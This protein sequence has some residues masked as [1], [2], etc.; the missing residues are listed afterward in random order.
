MHLLRNTII[1]FCFSDTYRALAISF[2][3]YLQLCPA[4]QFHPEFLEVNIGG[5]EMIDSLLAAPNV[6]TFC[7]SLYLS[8]VRVLIM[9]LYKMIRFY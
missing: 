4:V 6:L 5:T 1:G 7:G 9:D 8:S 3:H 2:Y